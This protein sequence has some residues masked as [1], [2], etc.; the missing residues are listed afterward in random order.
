MTIRS[1][2][3]FIS[4]LTLVACSSQRNAPIKDETQAKVDKAEIRTRLELVVE[5]G[6]VIEESNLSSADKAYLME[7]FEKSAKEMVVGLAEQNKVVSAM[8]NNL[9]LKNNEGMQT[10]RD[11]QK[12]FEDLE[13]ENSQRRSDILKEIINSLQGRVD[14]AKIDKINQVFSERGFIIIETSTKKK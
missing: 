5:L 8:I 13:K 11:L 6:A 14:Q 7:K 9:S 12:R 2:F 4:L 10:K 3:N 1:F